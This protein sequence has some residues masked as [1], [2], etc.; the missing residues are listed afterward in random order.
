MKL[1]LQGRRFDTT[2]EIHAESREV[3]DTHL[4]TSRDAWNGGKQAG[5]AVRMPKGTT[6]KETVE[7]K[8][9]G[10]KLFYGQIPQIFG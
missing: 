5:I 8:G 10:R 9:Y 4:R 6:L 2:E 3:I 7:N 1:R